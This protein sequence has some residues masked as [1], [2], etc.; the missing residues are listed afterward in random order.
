MATLPPSPSATYRREERIGLAVAAAAHLALVAVLLIQPAPEPLSDV[1]ERMTVS[2][3]ED[4]GLEATAP[5][6]VPESRAAT[7]PTRDPEPPTPEQ[8]TPVQRVVERTVVPDPTPRPRSQPTPRR[9]E[10]QPQPR[11][12]PA[13]RGG[14]TFRDA[15]RSGLGGNPDSSETR[16]PAATFGASEQA[17]LA[18]AIN[19][20]LRPHWRAPQG[21][22]ADKLVTVLSWRL[23]RDGS[24]AGTPRVVSQS[25]INDSNRAQ[26]DIH[27][28]QAIRAVQLAAPFNLP[29]Q[30]YDEWKLISDWRFDRR[31]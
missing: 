3:A 14:S 22:D 2:L 13:Q 27:A 1:P 12:Q 15:F 18:Q 21:V 25:G 7:A 8:V 9:A 10:P 20:Q 11:P 24:L 17:A 26:A 6:P 28:E 30:F 5:V 29:E 31:L 4:V 19:R 16:A 23:N